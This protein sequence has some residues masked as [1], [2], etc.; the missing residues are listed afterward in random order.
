VALDFSP[1]HPLTVTELSATSALDERGQDV[2]DLL[3]AADG[4]FFTMEPGEFAE[5]R[6]QVP[7]I[8]QG[9]ARTYLVRSTGWYRIHTPDVGEPDVTL[10][11]RV[12]TEPYA[13]SRISV[14]WMN[15]ALRAMQLSVR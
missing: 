12:L 10:L 5:V 13:I 7:E 3:A 15:E 8:P 9:Q 2:R 14:A 4:R 6:Y 1:E 11:N